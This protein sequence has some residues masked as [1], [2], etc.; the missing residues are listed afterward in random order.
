M[1]P[2]QNRNLKSFQ[3]V[4]YARK[5]LIEGSQYLTLRLGQEDYAIDILRVQEIR[6]YEVPTRMV[7]APLVHQGCH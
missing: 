4:G 1:E 5:N 3:S 7:H 2:M 6:S